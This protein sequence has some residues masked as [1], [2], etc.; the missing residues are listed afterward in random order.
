M[1]R[2]GR[3]QAYTRACPRMAAG[4]G[5]SP[6]TGGPTHVQF[7]RPCHPDAASLSPRCRA[8]HPN[9]TFLSLC[10]YIPVTPCQYAPDWFQDGL[11]SAQARRGFCGF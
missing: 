7:T 9:I 10:H 5:T 11:G 6:R 1:C 3:Q 4:A 2:W 8:C